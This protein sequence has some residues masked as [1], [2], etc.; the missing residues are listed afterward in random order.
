MT[1][2][3]TKIDPNY[4]LCGAL[5]YLALLV[6]VR[7]YRPI[8]RIPFLSFWCFYVAGYALINQKKAFPL[9]EMLAFAELDARK[10]R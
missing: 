3:M 5:L 4:E 6:W 10:K 7:P 8:W 2:K 9:F 1:M